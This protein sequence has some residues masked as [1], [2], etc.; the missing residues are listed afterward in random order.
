M[1]NQKR[2]YRRLAGE[3]MEQKWALVF[4]LFGAVVNAVLGIVYPLLTAGAIDEII[5]G[6]R[7]SFQGIPV[8]YLL[9][10]A[11]FAVFVIRSALAICRNISCP[12]SPKGW[13]FGCGGR[14][15]IS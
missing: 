7:H 13:R 11:L 3:L 6:S 9:L 10:G 5:S 8:F 1:K 15:A 12:A 4:V 14:S 2:T